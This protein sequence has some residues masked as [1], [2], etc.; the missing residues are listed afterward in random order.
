MKAIN[1]LVVDDK[2]GNLFAARNQFAGKNVNLLCCSLFS[3]AVKF[4]RERKFD[5]LLTDLMIPGEV[6]GISD[7]NPEIGKEVPYGLVLAIMAKNIGIKNVAIL[8]DISHHAGPIAWAM[9]N[10]MGENNFV[11]CFNSKD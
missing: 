3:V 8:S 2:Q 10:L 7:N 6:E 4:L 9:D 1:I 11:S 5:I